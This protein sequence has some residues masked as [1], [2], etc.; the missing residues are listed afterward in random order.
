MGRGLFS[1]ALRTM[2]LGGLG[3]FYPLHDR[4]SSLQTPPMKHVRA[5][6]LNQ[7]DK[8]SLVYVGD[9]RIR[10]PHKPPAQW[11]LSSNPSPTA[12]KVLVVLLYPESFEE[13]SKTLLELHAVGIVFDDE[14]VVSPFPFGPTWV[15]LRDG[16]PSWAAWSARATLRERADGQA[17]V[18]GYQWQDGA[19]YMNSCSQNK[20]YPYS[21]EGI[22]IQKGWMGELA[23]QLGA[24]LVKSPNGEWHT[25]H[26]LDKF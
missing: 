1:L 3:I 9:R 25:G 18:L 20:P 5:R 21:L 13:A 17:G 19:K 8:D 22:V 24:V 12:G 11:V 16:K 6:S 15:N 14:P 26:G 7:F 2:W 23:R 4:S 10:Y